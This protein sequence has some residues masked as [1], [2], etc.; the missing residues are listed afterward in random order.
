MVVQLR[1]WR[2][3]DEPILQKLA[4]DALV[5]RWMT[6][7]F[8]YP[9]TIE[10]A[11]AWVESCEK[12]RPTRHF[13]A[14]VDG[15]IVGGAAMEPRGDATHHGVVVIGYWLGRDYWRRGIATEI[16]RLLIER[17]Q[18]AGIRRLQAGVFAPNVAS[19]RVLEKSGFVL[20]GRLRQSYVDRDGAR[21][22]E[23]VYGLVLERTD[24]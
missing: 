22:D 18:V 2:D 4:N 1:P 10:D 23:L 19:A 6:S 21:A 24:D 3:G 20:E 14:E 16:V 7:E 8:R 12:V 15:A 13:A 5:S 9:Y 17:A 11:K